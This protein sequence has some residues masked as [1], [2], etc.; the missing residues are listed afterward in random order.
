M[1]FF[2]SRK[3]MKKHK[4]LFE[5]IAEEETED[6]AIPLLTFTS[7]LDEISKATKKFNFRC[8]IASRIEDTPIN[9]TKK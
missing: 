9:N 6:G 5:C 4:I 8:Y 7:L 3:N 2:H 1:K